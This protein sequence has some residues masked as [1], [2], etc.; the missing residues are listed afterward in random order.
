MTWQFREKSVTQKKYSVSAWYAGI[1]DMAGFRWSPQEGCVPTRA[2]EAPGMYQKGI[3]DAWEMPKKADPIHGK[4]AN[5]DKN[6]RINADNRL[7]RTDR[8]VKRAGKARNLGIWESREANGKRGRYSQEEL[9]KR[10]IDTAEMHLETWTMHMNGVE[11][12]E[13]LGSVARKQIQRN[14]QKPWGNWEHYMRNGKISKADGMYLREKLGDCNDICSRLMVRLWCS[15]LFHR[16]TPVR[17][18]KWWAKSCFVSLCG[19]DTTSCSLFN[20]EQICPVGEA[21]HSDPQ[22]NG[23]VCACKERMELSLMKQN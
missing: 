5:E 16:L 2:W 19:R 3:E 11:N 1:M 13:V 14:A 8:Q 18:W 6:V 22:G 20:I 15:H 4:N 9:W 7:K 23:G 10:L 12:A 21:E 17:N